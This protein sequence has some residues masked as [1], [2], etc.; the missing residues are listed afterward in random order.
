MGASGVSVLRVSVSA[1]PIAY[2]VFLIRKRLIL[3]II[4]LQ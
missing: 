3:Q 1:A 2:S 4:K